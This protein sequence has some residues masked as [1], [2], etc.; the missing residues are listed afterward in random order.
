MRAIEGGCVVH[1]SRHRGASSVAHT[2]ATG[3]P[4]EAVLQADRP[5]AGQRGPARWIYC[6]ACSWSAW[7]S[8]QTVAHSLTRADG[9][10]SPG[11]VVSV[12]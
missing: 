3:P 11:P 9:H 10:S 7:G 5:D 2:F 4:S 12:A 6:D 1:V 8:L